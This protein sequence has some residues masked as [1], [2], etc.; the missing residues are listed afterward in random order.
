M[1]VERIELTTDYDWLA[2]RQRYIG[3]SEVPT[4]CGVA[5]YG[6]LAELYAEKK[7]LRPPLADSA[8][9]RRGRW[10]EASVFQ[11]L[12]DERPEWNVVRSRL[13]VID[14][15][16]RLACTPDGF[17]TAPGR[18]GFGLIQAKVVS[19]SVFRSKW[20]ADPEDVFG[21]ASPPAHFVLQTV[22]ERMLNADRCPWAALAVLIN[23]EYDWSF[24]LFD[25]E[26]DP[27][28]EAAIREDVAAFWR[29]YLD[30]GIMPPFEPQRDERLIKHLF[31]ADDGTEIDL[32]QDNR[33]LVAVDELIEKQAALKRL[34]KD[35]AALKTELAAKLGACTY[36]RL[37][38][39]RRLSWKQQTRKAHAVEAS[40]YRVLR[41]L[42]EARA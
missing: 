41:I 6:S 19:R 8:V 39:G 5:A 12:A 38:D 40:T 30:P 10:G 32:T 23:G 18:E 17:A 28:V 24:R 34:E 33:A 15:E 26:P 7:G 35:E 27:E 3:A 14:R 37:A 29:D 20:L 16:A 25:I 36:G 13:H 2:E 21:P 1:P 4:V 42:K 22:C 31:P 11:A 9:L